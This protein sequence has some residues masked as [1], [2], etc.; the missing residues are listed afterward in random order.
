MVAYILFLT[1]L[2]LVG[3]LAGRPGRCPLRTRLFTGRG[4]VGGDQLDPGCRRRRGNCHPPS[5]LIGHS[6]KLVM[7]ITELGRHGIIQRRICSKVS[8]TFIDLGMTS[9]QLLPPPPPPPI[10]G[11]GVWVHSIRT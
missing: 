2:L 8:C 6:P 10:Y 9:K 4:R 11:D 5:K 7:L 3:C 1:L